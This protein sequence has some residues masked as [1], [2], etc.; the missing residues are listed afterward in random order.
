MPRAARPRTGEPATA[1]TSALVR[2]PRVRADAA[3]EAVGRAAGRAPGGRPAGGRVPGL[4]RCPRSCRGARPRLPRRA[5]HPAAVR[6]PGRA[7]VRPPPRR[8]VRAPLRAAHRLGACQRP[9]LDLAGH[10]RRRLPAGPEGPGRVPAGGRPLGLARRQPGPHHG[11]R[12]L[13]QPRPARARLRGAGRPRGGGRG[14]PLLPRRDRAAG[15]PR[16]RPRGPRPHPAEQPDRRLRHRR[17]L[18][19]GR[20]AHPLRP[21]ARP[22]RRVRLLLHRAA[23]AGARPRLHQHPRRL[24]RDRLLRHLL[25]PAVH[26]RLRRPRR[27]GPDGHGRRARPGQPEQDARRRPDERAAVLARQPRRPPPTAGAGRSCTPPRCG[28]PAA[29]SATSTRTP[30]RPGHRTPS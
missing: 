20:R 4:S 6:A 24:R 17:H 11:R 26:V 22:P 30:S 7:A 29:A 10:L 12:A 5:H 25:E 23:R 1:P 16:Q 27:H 2:V 13:P 28:R 18:P 9:A 15:R 19:E 14:R 21:R 3:G 8:H